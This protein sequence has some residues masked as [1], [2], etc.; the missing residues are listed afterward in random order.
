MAVSLSSESRYLEGS[1]AGA[2]F[3]MGFLVSI[4]GYVLY[5]AATMRE[6]RLPVW[7]G[8][9]FI[10]VGPQALLPTGEYAGVVV[11][12]LVWLALGYALLS[13]RD[14]AT[15]DRPRWARRTRRAVL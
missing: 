5:G 3:G 8:A 4:V 1:F 10:V 14:D 11:T 13:R 9:A 2:L 6:G 12:G 7:Y 15:S